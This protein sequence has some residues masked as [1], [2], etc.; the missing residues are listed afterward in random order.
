MLNQS[1]IPTSKICTFSEM[2]IA[3]LVGTPKKTLP[4]E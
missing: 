3:Y 1:N 2:G 4:D